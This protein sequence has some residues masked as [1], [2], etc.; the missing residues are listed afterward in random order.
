MAKQTIEDWYLTNIQWLKE[1][2][3]EVDRDWDSYNDLVLE[4]EVLKAILDVQ[5]NES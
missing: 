2:E 1:I 5:E 4:T 3:K